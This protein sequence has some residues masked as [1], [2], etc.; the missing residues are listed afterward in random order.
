MKDIRKKFKNEILNLKKFLKPKIIKYLEFDPIFL[1]KNDPICY[2]FIEKNDI[3][4]S[5]NFNTKI[6]KKQLKM[7][8]NIFI[9]SLNLH[10][11]QFPLRYLLYTQNNKSKTFL[12]FIHENNIKNQKFKNWFQ[13]LYKQMES[14]LNNNLNY[15]NIF[16]KYIIDKNNNFFNKEELNDL[17][18]NGYFKTDEKYIYFE[19][20][21]QKNFNIEKLYSGNNWNY[22]TKEKIDFDKKRFF[23]DDILLPQLLLFT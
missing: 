15:R 16:L 21:D 10:Y 2:D 13:N 8:K 1:D 19:L 23:L 7:K 4:I 9:N 3:F 22:W 20:V 5:L 14:A 18:N 11:N 6:I 12:D 17:F